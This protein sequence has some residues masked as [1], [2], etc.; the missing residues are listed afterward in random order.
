VSLAQVGPAVNLIGASDFHQISIKNIQPL[1][2]GIAE[3]AP[4]HFGFGS[5]TGEKVIP[6]TI[7][8]EI[9]LNGGIH[10]LIVRLEC[11]ART[12]DAYN[13]VGMRDMPF[14]PMGRLDFSKPASAEMLKPAC[15]SKGQTQPAACVSDNP[16][17]GPV[18]QQQRKGDLPC[19][20]L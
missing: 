18:R 16:G 20:W 3:K 1:T 5:Q 13:E 19:V 10:G 12:K 9:C 6:L 8:R 15:L 11:C 7:D 14:P 17:T 4:G 2:A